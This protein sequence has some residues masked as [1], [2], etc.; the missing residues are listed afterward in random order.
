MAYAKLCLVLASVSI[1]H[2]KDVGGCSL[3]LELHLPTCC[4]GTR[5]LYRFNVVHALHECFIVQ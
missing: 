5:T 3:V 4:E 2:L 1:W